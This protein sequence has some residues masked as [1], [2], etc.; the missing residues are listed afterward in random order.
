M[1]YKTN[2]DNV[3]AAKPKVGGGVYSAPA[4]TALPTDATTALNVAFKTLGF[5]SDDG[6]TNENSMS[7]DN[8]KAWGGEIVNSIQTEKSDIFKYKLIEA[9]NVDTLKETYGPDNVSGNLA[10]GITV[11][12]NASEL[13]IHP[14]V[15]ETLLKGGVIKRIVIPKGKVVEIDEITYGDSDNIGYGLTVQ[16]FPD[17]NGNTHYEYIKAGD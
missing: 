6:V 17:D 16:A 9:L 8:L 2:S 4:K 12:A 15:I 11:K 10:T 5:I 3:T 13:P 7:S 14:I 1:T